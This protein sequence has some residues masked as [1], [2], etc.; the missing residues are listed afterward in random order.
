MLEMQELC[1]N[2]RKLNINGLTLYFS[3]NTC[4]AFKKDYVLY[5]TENIWRT[6]T[7]KHLNMICP[8]HNE[9]MDSNNFNALLTYEL[10]VLNIIEEIR[11]GI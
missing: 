7:G 2:F 8:N 1:N 10:T 4:V 11:R 5:C 9:R 3:Y 6:V